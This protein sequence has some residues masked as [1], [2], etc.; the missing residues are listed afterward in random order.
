MRETKKSKFLN[1]FP[2]DNSVNALPTPWGINGSDVCI[3]VKVNDSFLNVEDTIK[4]SQMVIGKII[5]R[6]K[7]D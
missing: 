6:G 2:Q 1:Y 4:A 5:L 7:E 3:P